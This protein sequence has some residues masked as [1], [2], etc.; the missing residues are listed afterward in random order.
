MLPRLSSGI[1]PKT[2]VVAHVIEVISMYKIL[3]GKFQGIDR[4]GDL[5][6]DGRIIGIA[7]QV[8]FGE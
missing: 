5:D 8:Q 3:S 6:I 7:Q 2:I 1:T 4:F